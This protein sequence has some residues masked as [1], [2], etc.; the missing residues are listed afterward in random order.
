M[1]ASTFINDHSAGLNISFHDAEKLPRRD[2]FSIGFATF[3]RTTFMNFIHVSQVSKHGSYG[4]ILADISFQQERF[5]KIVI[6]GETGSGKSTLLRIVAGLDQPDTGKVMMNGSSINGLDS[7]IPGHP[8]IAYL[9]QQFELPKFIRVEQALEYA[10]KLSSKEAMKLY[11]ICQVDHLLKRKTHELSGGEQQ[12]IA[13]ARLLCSKP[14]LLLLD[15]P[16]S[17][18]DRMVKG[19]LKEVVEDIRTKL[20]TTIILVSHDPLDILSW[21]D[22][23]VVMQSSKVIQQGTP[24]EIYRQPVDEYAAGLFGPYSLLTTAQRKA[25]GIQQ[26][27]LL[28]RPEDFKIAKSKKSVRGKVT[29]CNFLGNQFELEVKVKDATIKVAHAQ[30]IRAGDQVMVQYRKPRL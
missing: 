20:K 25:F 17:N 12:R 10:N 15:E 29:G 24:K 2:L 1:F 5:E 18:L 6:A 13:L 7:L 28:A 21:A 16:Y 8:E 27:V 23:I 30:S 26:K 22:R 14:K 3:G 11:R 19:V 9:S 4:A